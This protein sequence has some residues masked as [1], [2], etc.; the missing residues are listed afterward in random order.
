MEVV[1]ERERE[2]DRGVRARRIGT[3]VEV[4]TIWDA[5]GSIWDTFG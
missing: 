1:G 5:T 4:G 3:A 2:G